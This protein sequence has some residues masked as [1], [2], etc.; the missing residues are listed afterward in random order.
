MQF[1]L[2]SNI[3]INYDLT[4][5]ETKLQQQMRTRNVRL[6][7]I[8][9]VK[10]QQK[11]LPSQENWMPFLMRTFFF[12]QSENLAMTQV[13]RWVLNNS[14]QNFHDMWYVT[15]F[16]LHRNKCKIVNN[17]VKL[18]KWHSLCFRAHCIL[19]D[20]IDCVNFVINVALVDRINI[21]YA[22]QKY[23]HLPWKKSAIR[24][25]WHVLTSY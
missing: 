15:S 24:E 23:I 16:T 11:L 9:T 10:V 6:L 13:S 1:K 21:V 17:S 4:L 18:S 12:W 20:Q 22:P 5:A 8:C 19:D 14:E 2:K 7:P 25:V 3:W